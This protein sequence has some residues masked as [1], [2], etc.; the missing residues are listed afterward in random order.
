VIVFFL[1]LLA[2]LSKQGGG[3]IG[4]S[5]AAAPSAPA[6]YPT[7]CGLALVEMPNTGPWTDT[8]IY[9]TYIPPPSPAAV[10][11][12]PSDLPA[13]TGPAPIPSTSPPGQDGSNNSSSSGDESKIAALKAAAAAEKEKRS[14]VLQGVTGGGYFELRADRY[15][16]PDTEVLCG[17]KLLFST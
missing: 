10:A 12:S 15:Q 11:G 5:G 4:G 9:P 2:P 3:L 13:A 1:L 14:K 6:P 16:A 17:R 8:T 7:L